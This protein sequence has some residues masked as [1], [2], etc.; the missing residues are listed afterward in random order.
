MV[1]TLHL[2]LATLLL[3]IHIFNTL[4]IYHT[5][6]SEMQLSALKATLQLDKWVIGFF[7]LL[8]ATGTLIVPT[9]HWHYDT[10]WISAAYRSLLLTA[11]LWGSG[12][13]LKSQRLKGKPL[14][15][16]L[17]NSISLAIFLFLLLTVKDAV[18][19]HPWI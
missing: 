8:L 5:R 10:P 16:T 2:L 4:L 11:L 18:T 12:A 9:Y 1:K 6:H 3:G 19:K 17:L 15:H 14:R 7:I 13:W